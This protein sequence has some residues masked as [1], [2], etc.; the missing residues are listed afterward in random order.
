V[1]RSRTQQIERTLGM[2]TR[3]LEE[4]RDDIGRAARDGGDIAPRIRSVHDRAGHATPEFRT[5][6]IPLPDGFDAP[7]DVLSGAIAHYA[8]ERAP[9]CLLLAMEAQEQDG[10]GD[11]RTLLIAEARDRAGTRMYWMQA[12]RLTAA[13]VDWEEPLEGGWRDPGEAEMILDAAFAGRDLPP[14][15]PRRPRRPR[16]SARPRDADREVALPALRAAR[17]D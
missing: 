8:R 11:P 10:A 1:G 9:D 12:F 13:A 16:A 7:P 5:L 17:A 2:A 14:E 6:A 3:F 4:V 15:P